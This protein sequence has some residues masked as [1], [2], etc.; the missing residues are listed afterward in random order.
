MSLQRTQRTGG[1]VKLAAQTVAL[2]RTDSFGCLGFGTAMG[3]MG[4]DGLELVLQDLWEVIVIFLY[5]RGLRELGVEPD[6]TIVIYAGGLYYLK[7]PTA[8]RACS[9]P[10][11]DS[12]PQRPGPSG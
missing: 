8:T 4:S 2:E 7:Q 10:K 6:A 12:P 11:L 5:C 9:K 3:L 1:S